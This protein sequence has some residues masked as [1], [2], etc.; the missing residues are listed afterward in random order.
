[1]QGTGCGVIGASSPSKNREV[2]GA[3][4][5]ADADGASGRRL[6]GEGGSG[7]WPDGVGGCDG[8]WVL[9]KAR[10]ESSVALL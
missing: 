6:A 7:A 2:V 10:V 9:V 5:D 4:D 3:P 1:M 8:G